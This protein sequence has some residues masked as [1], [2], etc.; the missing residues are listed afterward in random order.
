MTEKLRRPYVH[1]LAAFEAFCSEL[2]RAGFSPLPDAN[3]AQWTGPLPEVLSDLTDA[4]AMSVTIV[5]GWP[6][7][8]ARTAV[9]GLIADHVM[10]G[11][12]YICL[13]ADDDPGQL[14]GQTWEGLRGRLEQW[15]EGAKTAFGPEGGALDAWAMFEGL[16]PRRAEIDLPG[17]VGTNPRN[18]DVH[19]LH[20]KADVLLTLTRGPAADHPLEGVVL[21]RSVVRQTPRNFDALLSCLTRRQRENLMHG[22][23]RRAAVEE[24]RASGGYDFAVLVWPKHGQLEA[25]VISFS[26][27]KDSLRAVPHIASPRDVASRLR[28]AGSDAAILRTRRV[29][30]VGVGAIGGQVALTLASSGTGVLHLSDDDELRSV[31]LVRHVLPAH[32]VGYTKTSGLKVLIESASPWCEV[33]TLGGLSAN[34][35]E[36]AEI[37]R[38]FDLVV[39]CTG[40]F[41]TTLAIAQACAVEQVPFLT[42][43]LFRE[44]RA[45]RIRRQLTTDTPL[46]RRAPP[47]YPVI[48]AGEES[49]LT[50]FLELG[51]TSPVHNSPP[52]AVTRAAADT[53]LAAVAILAGRSRDAEDNVTVLVALDA[54]PFDRPGTYGFPAAPVEAPV[55]EV[56]D[57]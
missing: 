42:V 20:G 37:V 23:G 39:D 4:D 45:F 1:D 6:A 18:G 28:R 50:G 10:P 15:A 29:L 9:P 27:D 43:A 22:V 12:G 52:A 7:V 53:A 19:V 21:Y 30:L 16:S 38:G 40:M 49:G 11:T 31:N 47:E 56:I 26:G 57:E 34:P 3:Q 54:E 2:V 44:G 25:L 8:A 24:G 13:W 5:D 35:E 41:A 14:A 46:V 33:T 51:C 32:M 17:L 36:V 48:P 55:A